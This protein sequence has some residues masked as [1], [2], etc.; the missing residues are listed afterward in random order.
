MRALRLLVR[1][2]RHACGR[3]RIRTH[4]VSCAAP[5]TPVGSELRLATNSRVDLGVDLLVRLLNPKILIGLR[6]AQVQCI[7]AIAMSAQQHLILA[8]A[9]LEEVA[10]RHFR[11]ARTDER[12]QSDIHAHARAQ[13]EYGAR[14][15][16][17]EVSR[18]VAASVALI[19]Y[20]AC[21]C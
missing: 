17:G 2:L 19:A 9:R 7:V 21:N 8:Q 13:E 4:T 20:R 14:E 1:C 11:Q 16:A 6:P 18:L 5:S 3:D 10:A 15:A 12:E